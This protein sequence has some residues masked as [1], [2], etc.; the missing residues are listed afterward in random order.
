MSTHDHFKATFKPL[1]TTAGVVKI[2]LRPLTQ[3]K[4]LRSTNEL[5]HTVS[6]PLSSTLD[7]FLASYLNILTHSDQS[8]TETCRNIRTVRPP[9]LYLPRWSKRFARS[10]LIMQK[11]R[12]H[13]TEIRIIGW[14]RTINSY[15]TKQQPPD[16][17][18]QNV[19]RLRMRN[20]SFSKTP[21][22]G[23]NRNSVIS[24]ASNNRNQC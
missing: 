12:Q 23:S 4:V 15:T 24:A 20:S 8:D 21:N 22:V 5:H 1:T 14:H 17:L 19:Y 13:L 18:I 6:E 10:I 9:N 3:R 16:W 11:T 2:T 7:Y